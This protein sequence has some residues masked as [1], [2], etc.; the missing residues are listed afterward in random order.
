MRNLHIILI[1][2]IFDLGALAALR[3]DSRDSNDSRV[4]L[5]FRSNKK[6]NL[7]IYIVKYYREWPHI[8]VINPISAFL[9]YTPLII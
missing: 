8:F 6:N 1:P 9:I 4:S 2:S 7:F 5:F 3:C